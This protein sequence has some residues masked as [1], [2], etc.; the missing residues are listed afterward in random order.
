MEKGN[1]FNIFCRCFCFFGI[2]KYKD[3]LF[4]NKEDKLI[5][6][7]YNKMFKYFEIIFNKKDWLYDIFLEYGF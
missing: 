5:I 4:I 2:W 3:K 1:I 7:V 6:L